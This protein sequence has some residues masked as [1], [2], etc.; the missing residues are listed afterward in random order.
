IPETAKVVYGSEATTATPTN[1]LFLELTQQIASAGVEDEKYPARTIS[2]I[3]RVRKRS[4][5]PWNWSVLLAGA[6][7]VVIGL[8]V[9]TA[10][11]LRMFSPSTV[12]TRQADVPGRNPAVSLPKKVPS[13]KSAENAHPSDSLPV[14]APEKKP[15]PKEK[16]SSESVPGPKAEPE[17]KGIPK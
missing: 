7:V 9:I 6:L 1:C 10:F 15:V 17:P 14:A 16:V 4:R 5:R 11:S 3:P 12:H 2:T 8:A 13:E